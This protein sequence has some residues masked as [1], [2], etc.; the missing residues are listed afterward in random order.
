[1]N[2]GTGPATELC[3]FPRLVERAVIVYDRLSGA[4]S[5]PKSRG[6]LNVRFLEG[7]V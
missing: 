7:V 5:L 3:N 2:M 6:R 4:A 1:M